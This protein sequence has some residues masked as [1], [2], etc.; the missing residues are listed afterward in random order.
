MEEIIN[1]GKVKKIFK[2]SHFDFGYY[3][4]VDRNGQFVIGEE[5]GREGGELYRGEYKGEITPY[6]NSVKN[7][8]IKL[9]NSIVKYFN[10]HK[11]V[12]RGM[13]ENCRFCEYLAVAID[14]AE[15]A[16]SN[17]TYS[18]Y[19]ELNND[20]INKIKSACEILDSVLDDMNIKKPM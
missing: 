15:Q 3:A 11:F 14:N 10:E 1:H 5:R 2:G 13:E 17:I 7:E 9:Y 12:D 19:P 16:I 20:V 4:F 6:L 8:N 18:K